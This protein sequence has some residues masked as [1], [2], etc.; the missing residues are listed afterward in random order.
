MPGSKGLLYLRFTNRVFSEMGKSFSAISNFDAK[1]NF[2]KSFPLELNIIAKER[3]EIYFRENG[4]QL[5]SPGNHGNWRG[6]GIS[7]SN[8]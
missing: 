8:S 5:S 1:I 7:R 4:R 3:I 2:A 6:G